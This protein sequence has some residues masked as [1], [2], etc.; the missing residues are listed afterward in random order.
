MERHEQEYQKYI[1]QKR[2]M[3]LESGR[4]DFSDLEKLFV[5]NA[6]ISGYLC[7]LQGELDDKTKT[8]SNDD[9]KD[10][11]KCGGELSSKSVGDETFNVC[12]DCGYNEA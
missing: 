5:K 11:G 3:V 12:S 10:C 9:V 2:K 4:K 8:D 7:A 1:V 6:F